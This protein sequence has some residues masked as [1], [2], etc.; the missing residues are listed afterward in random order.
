MALVSSRILN[1]V[2]SL[3]DFLAFLKVYDIAAFAVES[4]LETLLGDDKAAPIIERLS[5]ESSS[6]Q[7]DRRLSSGGGEA[8][9]Q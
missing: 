9:D 7:A 8:K 3:G 5:K 6:N 2:F 4:Q 1:H